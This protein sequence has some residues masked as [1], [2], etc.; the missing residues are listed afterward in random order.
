MTEG[1]IAEARKLALEL[2]SEF[3]H[4]PYALATE[5]GVVLVTD[6]RL[7]PHVTICTPVIEGRTALL[8]SA[9]LHV[10]EEMRIVAAYSGSLALGTARTLLGAQYTI[11]FVRNA[12]S[13]I[14]ADAF[15]GVADTGWWYRA[16]RA[17]IAG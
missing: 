15:L 8:V 17:R 1:M 3:N 7:R 2:G 16:N 14:F 5:L 11:R 10:R 13:A 12:L 4:D 9:R 6:H